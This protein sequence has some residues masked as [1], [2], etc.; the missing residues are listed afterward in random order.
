MSK[1]SVTKTKGVFGKYFIK[2]ISSTIIS[3]ALL[4]LA[5]S[6]I[7]FKLDID[8]GYLKYAAGFIA[9]SSS[10]IIALFC[11]TDFKNNLIIISII[12]QIPLLLFELFNFIRHGT[13]LKFYLIN[14]ALVITGALTAAI[15]KSLKKR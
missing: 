6:F 14:T 7:F 2:L 13:D 8:L 5:F 11:L 10:F 9:F 15:I 1:I 12:S 3:V 4:S